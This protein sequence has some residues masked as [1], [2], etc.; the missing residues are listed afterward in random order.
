VKTQNEGQGEKTA[1]QAEADPEDD[2]DAEDCEEDEVILSD[3]GVK[4]M[5]E[6][7]SDTRSSR[8][9]TFEKAATRAATVKVPDTVTIQ[10]KKYKVTAIDD[11]AFKNHK[12]VRE[13]VIGK[14]IRR[15]GKRAF[16][17]C[18]K[19]RRITIKSRKLTAK[20]IKKNAF[21]GIGRKVKI[22]VPKGKKKAYTKLFRSKGLSKKVKVTN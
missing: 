13:I 9:V 16:S 14:N 8:T 12:T 20:K 10:G 2:F 7:E 11:D 22:K 3:Q 18:E 17:G 15:I 1:S 21:K 6:I 4:V 5:Y 19:L